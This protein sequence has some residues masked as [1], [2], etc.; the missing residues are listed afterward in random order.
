MA[1][2]VYDRIGQGYRRFR[3]SDPR[4]ADLISASLG[5]VRSVINVGAGAGS[6]EPTDR[7]VLAIEPSGVMISQ[8]PRGSARC[9]RG[10]AEALPVQSR[11]FD[12]A[13]A[14]LTI[15]HW[16]DWRK[17]LAE[18]RRVARCRIVILTSDPEAW[19]FWLSDYFPSIGREDREIF[20]TIESIVSVLGG[21][22]IIPVPVPHDCADGFLA[23]YWRRPE[24]YLDP[25]VRQSMSSFSKFDPSHGLARLAAELENGSW[26]EQNRRLL[27]L[28]S[29]DV[30]YRLLRAEIGQVGSPHER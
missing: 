24:A 19:G 8:R 29:L 28:Q 26:H 14:I 30:G 2:A 17:G 22:E 4:I 12:A 1:G 11:S 7:E 10:T 25:A 23:A 9:I 27:S 6:Y 20:P 13:M 16:N 21:A 18:L 15:H 5:D 3:R